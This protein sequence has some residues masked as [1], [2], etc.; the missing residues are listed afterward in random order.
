M[1]KQI[2][3]RTLLENKLGNIDV[4]PLQSPRTAIENASRKYQITY[5]MRLIRA[6]LH[7]K[8]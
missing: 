6:N 8:P 7:L 2:D 4:Q 1:S 3:L 5:I